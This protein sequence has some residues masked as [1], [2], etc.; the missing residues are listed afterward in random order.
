MIE[1]VAAIYLIICSIIID[2]LLRPPKMRKTDGRV[3]D[4]Y[5][6]EYEDLPWMKS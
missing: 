1:L 5:E 6:L 4:A 3:L 2:S